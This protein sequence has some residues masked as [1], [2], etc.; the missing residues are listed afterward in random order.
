MPRSK[1]Y[2]YDSNDSANTPQLVVKKSLPTGSSAPPVKRESEVKL[3]RSDTELHAADAVVVVMG[4]TGA[5]KS[6]FIREATGE[7]VEVGD[8]L[9]SSEQKQANLSASQNPH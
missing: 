4:P 8:S 5:G 3:L 9:Q 6:R 2:P 1:Y 7:D